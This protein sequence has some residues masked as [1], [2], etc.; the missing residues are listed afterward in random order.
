M[1]LFINASE[2]SKIFKSDETRLSS[3]SFDC[4]QAK[5]E[6]T[7][8]LKTKNCSRTTLNRPWSDIGVLYDAQSFGEAYIGSSASTG[9]GLLVTLWF[10]FILFI[11]NT[12]FLE[13]LGKAMRPSRRIER[14]TIYKDGA[15]NSVSQSLRHPSIPDR[16]QLIPLSTISSVESKIPMSSFHH[17]NVSPNKNTPS[18]ILSLPFHLRRE[19]TRTKESFPFLIYSRHCDLNNF[20]MV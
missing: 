6:F 7:I 16:G 12:F 11:D 18:E 19:S 10:V 20:R 9:D 5:L 1:I 17:D 4:F 15:M 13:H 14:S 3:K 2:F 8:D